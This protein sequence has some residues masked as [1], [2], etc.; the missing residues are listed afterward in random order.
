[1]YSARQKYKFATLPYRNFKL[2]YRCEYFE[3][4][5]TGYMGCERIDLGGVHLHCHYLNR[6]KIADIFLIQ[7]RIVI[8]LKAH[9]ETS[10]LF[11][12][13]FSYLI[14]LKKM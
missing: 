2:M 6:I 4:S 8:L 13:Y 1:M 7:G 12:F 10:T 3:R 9:N 14:S 11:Y 5:F